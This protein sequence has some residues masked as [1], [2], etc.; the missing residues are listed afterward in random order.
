MKNQTYLNILE[1]YLIKEYPKLRGTSSRPGALTFQMD[2]ARP[3]S[4]DPVHDW[5]QKMC[6]RVIDWPS[7]SPDLNP[8]ENLWGLLQDSFYKKMRP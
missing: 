4:A 1:K 7:Y 5:F 3:Y 8:I 6:I 2:K